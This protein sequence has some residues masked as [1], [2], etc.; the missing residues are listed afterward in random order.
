MNRDSNGKR[1]K[2]VKTTIPRSKKRPAD[3]NQLAHFLGERST[4]EKTEATNGDNPSQSEISRVMAALG[5]K[6]GKI[7]GRARADALSESRR[8]AIAKNAAK[9]RWGKTRPAKT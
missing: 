3:V 7:G 9:A 2:P 6:G 1:V 5:R 8:V 4:K